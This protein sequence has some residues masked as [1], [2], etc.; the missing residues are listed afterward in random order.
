MNNHKL[1]LS[2]LLAV[3]LFLGFTSILLS[4]TLL[5]DRWKSS[6]NWYKVKDGMSTSQIKEILGPPS[7]YGTGGMGPIWYYEGNV[8]GSGNVTG[9]IQFYRGRVWEIEIPVFDTPKT[10]TTQPISDRWKSSTNWYKVKDGMSTSQIKEILGPPSSYGTGGMG[11]IWYYEGNVPGSGNVTG[12]IQFYRGRV[13]EIEIP[14][15]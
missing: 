14:V 4:S 6:T 7:S 2:R 10:S 3:F 5:T 15:F 12:L 9:L 8:P 13:W 11:P 1:L